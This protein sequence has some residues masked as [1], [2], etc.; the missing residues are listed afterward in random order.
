MR[1]RIIESE[2]TKWYVQMHLQMILFILQWIRRYQD[3]D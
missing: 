1:S 3:D 2:W